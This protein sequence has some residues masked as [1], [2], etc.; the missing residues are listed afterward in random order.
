M[1]EIVK[2]SPRNEDKKWNPFMSEKLFAHIY[3]W[4]KIK[5]GSMIP[6]PVFVTV[7]PTNL[8][9]FDCVWCNAKIIRRNSPFSISRNALMSIADFLPIWGNDDMEVESVCVAGGGEPLMNPATADF[10]DRTI[11]NGIEVGLITN[12]LHIG[13]F[14]GPI[15][16]C[17]WVSVSV[18]AASAETHNRLKRTPDSETFSKVIDN[19]SGLVDHAR[20]NGGRLGS[21]L[22]AYGVTYKYLLHRGNIGEVYQAAK[23]AKRIGCKNICYRPAVTPYHRLRTEGAVEFSGGDIAM[24]KEQLAEALQLNDENFNVYEYTYRVGPGFER[25][26]CFSKCF[27]IF[28]TAIF[29]APKYAD[30]PRDSFTLGLCC[31]RRGD[32]IT[33]LLQD[34]VDV[35][36]ISGAWG[37]ERHWEIHDR[38]DQDRQCPQCTHVVHNKI[39]EQCILN[40]GLTYK[41]I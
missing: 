40:D 30:S 16:K 20:N 3:R 11:S 12:G 14:M 29:Q 33:E 31:D 6:A 21:S 25:N 18:D 1:P 4:S 13:E 36:K 34:A 41:F 2:S 26:N 38:I 17:T 10:I 23:L 19:I 32:G 24:Y 28:M 27:S 7:D 15:S 22:P 8:C 9:E 5:R 39:Y 35:N 37:S